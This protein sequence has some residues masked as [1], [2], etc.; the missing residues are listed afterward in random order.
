[1]A[2]LELDR[3]AFKSAV[4]IKIQKVN[5]VGIKNFKTKELLIARNKK[6]YIVNESLT[7]KT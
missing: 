7:S 1:M 2:E 5:E 6:N 4:V 3:N